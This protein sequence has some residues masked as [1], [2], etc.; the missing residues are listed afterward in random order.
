[1]R[2]GP[3]EISGHCRGC[4]MVDRPIVDILNES[5]EVIHVCIEVDAKFINYED[6]FDP[7][8]RILA[9][10]DIYHVRLPCDC[11]VSGIRKLTKGMES[12]TGIIRPSSGMIKQIILTS[13]IGMDTKHAGKF[14]IHPGRTL[15]DLRE[16]DSCGQVVGIEKA[17]DDDDY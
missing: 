4:R 2:G 1:M 17:L 5:R 7:S 10:R 3:S 9:P 16:R 8:R 13:T 6:V 11:A 12:T 14:P 15:I